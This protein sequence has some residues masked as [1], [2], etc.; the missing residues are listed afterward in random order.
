MSGEPLLVVD[1]EVEHP[2]TL[3]FGALRDWPEAEQ[4]RDVSRFHPKRHGDAVSFHGILQRA[5]PKDSANY[6]TL[7]ADRD[8][9]HVSVPLALLRDQG[10]VVYSRD[11]APLGPSDHGPIRFLVRDPSSCNTGELDEC[12]NVK[13]LNRIEITVRKGRDTRPTDEAEHQALHGA[14]DTADWPY[15]P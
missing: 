11:G 4:I 13:Y 3:T 8:D 2:L 10:M 9:F 12:T 15:Q 1:G 14:Q 7:H 6:V 5:R